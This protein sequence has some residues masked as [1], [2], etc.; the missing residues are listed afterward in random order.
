MY[1]Y[2]GIHIYIHVY[3]Y[4]YI[5]IYNRGPFSGS[6]ARKLQISQMGPA[7]KSVILVRT[8]SKSYFLCLRRSKQVL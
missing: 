5:S 8:I 4:I 3:I 1:I 7:A 2:Q 6:K